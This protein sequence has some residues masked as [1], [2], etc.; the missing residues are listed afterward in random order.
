MG[1]TMQVFNQMFD[2]GQMHA[3]AARKGITI[4]EA[5]PTQSRQLDVVLAKTD[6]GEYVTWIYVFGSFNGGHY[7]GNDIQAAATDFMER[8]V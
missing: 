3:T 5:K 8:T 7:F 6:R 1:F 4:L 2:S